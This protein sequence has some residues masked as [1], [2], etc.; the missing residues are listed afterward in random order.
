MRT[1]VSVETDLAVNAVKGT[2]LAVPRADIDTKRNAEAAA[3][4]RAENG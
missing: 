3:V 1:C 2:D 4:N